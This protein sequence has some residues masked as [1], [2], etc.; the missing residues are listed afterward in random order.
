M[1]LLVL[2]LIGVCAVVA[3]QNFDSPVLGPVDRG[4]QPVAAPDLRL[5]NSI[6]DPYTNPNP[7]PGAIPDVVPNDRDATTKGTNGVE[8][9]NGVVPFPKPPVEFEQPIVEAATSTSP[10]V[11]SFIQ[12]SEEKPKN[13]LRMPK[14]L[15]SLLREARA[16]NG[17]G[18]ISWTEDPRP[19]SI[20]RRNYEWLQE[21][22]DRCQ[23]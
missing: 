16:R 5:S 18:P 20:E 3:T 12:L 19:Q 23:A 6:P 9:F 1:R 7:F 11:F 2:L 10:D 15:K 8:S 14:K 4:G 13:R 17:K 22:A 21:Q